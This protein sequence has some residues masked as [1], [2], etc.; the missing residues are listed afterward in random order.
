MKTLELI[1][2]DTKNKDLG[3]AAIA[4]V[5]EPAIEQNF[6]YFGAVEMGINTGG[7]SPY[8]DQVTKKKNKTYAEIISELIPKARLM[9]EED[10]TDDD[11]AAL[12]Y[13]ALADESKVPYDWT[14]MFRYEGEGPE[15]TF[16]DHY[17]QQELSIADIF[18]MDAENSEFG[19]GG[20]S[21]YDKFLYK[22]GPNCKHYW[23]PSSIFLRYNDRDETVDFSEA[24]HGDLLKEELD[25]YG[26]SKADFETAKT[27]MYDQSNHGYLTKH[28]KYAFVNEDQRTVA[29]PIMIPDI[30]IL[31]RDEDTDKLY[32]V[33]FS[34][35]TIKAVSE[36]YMRELKINNSNEQHDGAKPVDI[37]MLESWIIED[38]KHDKSSTYGFDLPVGTWFGSFR[39]NSDDVWAKVKDGTFRGFSI[40]GNFQEKEA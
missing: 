30:K 5:S 15:R 40:E 13:L 8:V 39:I 6:Y 33:F 17:W 36:K 16:C 34:K 29:G 19:P 23:K 9:T 2:L 37:T 18:F 20:N 32:Q 1:V 14:I 4:L 26:Y 35:D 38:P 10:L 28:S 22:G 31:R 21:G 11:L 27:P 25:I 3:V 24:K 12:T 7:L